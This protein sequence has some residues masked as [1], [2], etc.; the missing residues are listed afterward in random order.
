MITGWKGSSFLQS[1]ILSFFTAAVEAALQGSPRAP[2]QPLI[3]TIT[4]RRQPPSP[5]PCRQTPQLR[6][7][8]PPPCRPPLFLIT[9]ICL[10]RL[11]LC[12][13]LLLSPQTLCRSPDTQLGVPTQV[14]ISHLTFIHNINKIRYYCQLVNRYQYGSLCISL[15]FPSPRTRPSPAGIKHSFPGISEC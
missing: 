14:P 11:L 9:P 1:F 3:C 13:H 4:N 15:P 12:L 5:C 8:F 2:L 7:P 10:R 6:T